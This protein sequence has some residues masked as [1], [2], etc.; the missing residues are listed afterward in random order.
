MKHNISYK[1]RFQVLVCS[2]VFLLTAGTGYCESLFKTYSN[3]SEQQL[4]SET[5]TMS[6]QIRDQFRQGDMEAAQ[7]KIDFYD[8][9]ANLKK[10]LLYGSRLA[11]YSD[12]ENDLEFARDNERFKGLP[13]A[14]TDD[15]QQRSRFVDE[16]YK[17]MQVSVSDEIETY[18][19]LIRMSL[20]SCEML[21]SNDLSGFA[22]QENA[23]QR[24]RIYFETSR[25]FNEYMAKKEALAKR[26]PD[27]ES[28]INRQ[29]VMWS[30]AGPAPDDPV[31]NPEITQAISNAHTI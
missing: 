10:L 13:E 18:E 1:R 12:Y 20:D 7:Q 26:W 31:I 9:M 15:A 24:V 23:R 6:G 5:R 4:K 21:A 30:A 14:E 16:K 28:R 25:D 29:I 22:E 27:L 19:D 17:R 2:L 11:T 3:M 8:Y